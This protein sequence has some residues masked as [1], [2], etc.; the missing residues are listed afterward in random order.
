MIKI[1]EDCLDLVYP[2]RCAICGEIVSPKGQL[3]CTDCYPRA[4]R[5]K[6]PRC[7]CCGKEVASEEQEFC[8]DCMRRETYFEYGFSLWNYTD[9]MRKSIAAYK[10]HHRKEY[11]K[12]YSREF[13]DA[14]GAELMD[15]QPDALIPVPVH[16]TR[17]IERGYNQTAV[18]AKQIGSELD[19]PVL[20]DV[21]LRKRKTVAQKKLGH[22]E[23]AKNLAH[24]FSVSEK[25]KNMSKSL[26]RV[27]LID[28]IYTTG[29]TLNMC[30]KVLKQDADVEV[31]FGVLCIGMGY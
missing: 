7:L 17:Y 19:I 13:V 2:R 16:W 31:Y 6:E 4:Q 8:M 1:I 27:V 12:F 11:A 30:A 24:A 10:Y 28:D 5:V 22:Q 25:W 23:R 26:S 15:L 14:F 29:S 20:E 9:A 21:L 3:V 18:L